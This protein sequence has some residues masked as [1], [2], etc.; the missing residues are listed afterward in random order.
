MAQFPRL[1]A[2]Y[3][4][5]YSPKNAS[6]SDKYSFIDKKNDLNKNNEDI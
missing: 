2:K 5:A 1:L 3:Q 6:S 4:K